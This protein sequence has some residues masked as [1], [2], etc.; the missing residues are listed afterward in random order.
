MNR[1]DGQMFGLLAEFATPEALV[2]AARSATEAGY[3]RVEAYSPFPVE[4]I[5]EALARPGT[6]IPLLALIGGVLGALTAYGME[7]YC[8]AIGYPINVG[9]RPL[10]SWP[11]FMPIVF[12]L[13]VLG[14]PCLPFSARWCSTVFPTPTIRCSMC[15]IQAGQ[16]RSVLL[17]DRVS[18][19]AVSA[20][21]DPGVSHQPGGREGL[22]GAAMRL[23]AAQAGSSGAGT[24]HR[25]RLA[26]GSLA[27]LLATLAGCDM[28]DMY[29]QPRYKP[30]ARC[31]FF[32]TACRPGRW[33][34]ARFR[35]AGSRGYRVLHWKGRR[36][37]R[38]RAAAAG[39][40][41]LLERGRERFTMFCS[42]CHGQTGYGNG[43]VVQRGFKQPPSYHGERVQ[44]LADG[45]FFEIISNGFG[46][47]PPLNLQTE[48][49]DRWA[50][51]AYIR[52]LQ[53]SQNARLADVPD[54]FQPEAFAG[55]GLRPSF[56]RSSRRADYPFGTDMRQGPQQRRRPARRCPTPRRRPTSSRRSCRR[57]VG[58]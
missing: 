8:L 54:E 50:I 38:G 36:P 41:C 5:D 12:E 16:P 51:V 28:L 15:R 3:D 29:D 58:R 11:S 18:R 27:S 35:A 33:W 45:N 37:V 25:F 2:A 39:R 26:A 19:S 17:V 13:T 40:R 49:R 34:R 43:M 42:M 9:G 23:D 56:G 52:A 48:P 44:D 32:P 20:R 10:N 47:M 21:S 57:R 14:A 22:R 30:L 7:Y 6:A 53:L 24:R 55:A 46:Q 1:S 4:G 31:D